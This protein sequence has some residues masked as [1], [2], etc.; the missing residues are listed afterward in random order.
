MA[1]GALDWGTVPAWFSGG[2]V[3]LAVLVYLRDRREK[4]LEQVECIGYW[5]DFTDKD[6][7][8]EAFGETQNLVVL[9]P[10]MTLTNT[11]S[12][13]MKIARVEYTMHYRWLVPHEQGGGP[14]PWSEGKS[15]LAKG[16]WGDATIPPSGE[17][18][19]YT[20]GISVERPEKGAVIDHLGRRLAF[21]EIL[22]VDGK[23]RRWQ[24]RPEKGT[25]WKRFH[26]Y[27]MYLKLWRDPV[28]PW[29]PWHTPRSTRMMQGGLGKWRN[30][31]LSK[32]AKN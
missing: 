12:L 7:K 29:H 26:R 32:I 24:I 28:Q 27:H 17:I 18:K 30:G 21:D 6:W 1:M 15:C 10:R 22:V 13:P 3:L 31:R 14:G 8:V 19:P 9:A 5:G 20:P 23:G 16:A 4:R 25:S 11:G 2:S